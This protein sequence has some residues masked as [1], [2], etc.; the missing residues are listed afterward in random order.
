M[1]FLHKNVLD[2]I[3]W[4]TCTSLLY[5]YTQTT[6]GFYDFMFLGIKMAG[7]KHFNINIFLIFFGFDDI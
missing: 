1:G 5:L 3:S 2:V 6:Q 7:W 4:L